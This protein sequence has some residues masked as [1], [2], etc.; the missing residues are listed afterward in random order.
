MK[1]SVALCTYNG[2]SYLKDH[3]LSIIHQTVLPDELIICDDHS[4]DKTVE[5]INSLKAL[6]SFPMFLHLNPVNLGSTKNF[7]KAF[8]LCN[9]EIIV[10][11]DQDDIW[12][13]RKIEAIL[14][15]FSDHPQAG[16]VFSDAELVD[17][18]CRPL[19]MNLWESLGF[20]EKSLHEYVG[21]KQIET[22]I[23]RNIVT[24]TTMAMK[25]SLKELIFPFPRSWIHDEWIATLVS[26]V[27]IKGVPIPEALVLYRQHSR[28]QIG[29]YKESMREIIRNSLGTGAADYERLAS[30]Y[31]EILDRIVERYA[32]LDEDQRR[33]LALLEGKVNHFLQRKL[34]QSSSGWSKCKLIIHEARCGH[35]HSYSFGFLSIGRDLFFKGQDE[36]KNYSNTKA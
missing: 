5:I 35:Y 25:E 20:D 34:I 23:R 15:A 11:A 3:L 8:R 31:R 1:I 9:G 30:A 22:T 14:K 24:G 17:A 28:Q 26:I 27:G 10:F 36:P 33:R 16:F 29:V 6:Y 32:E 13:P 21:G 7:E 12:K 4:T 19:G 18:H 2:E